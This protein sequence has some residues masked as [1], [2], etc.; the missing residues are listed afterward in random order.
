MFAS[1]GQSSGCTDFSR[2]PTIGRSVARFV[3]GRAAAAVSARIARLSRRWVVDNPENTACTAQCSDSDFHYH[4]EE[5]NL[6]WRADDDPRYVLSMSTDITE[7]KLAEPGPSETSTRNCVFQG[8]ALHQQQPGNSRAFRY[9]S[10]TM[11]WRAPL[12]AIDG[13]DT[14]AEEDYGGGWM[15]REGAPRVRPRQHQAMERLSRDCWSS[16]LGR[17]PVSTQEIKRRIARR[18][19]VGRSVGRAARRPPRAGDRSLPPVG[20]IARCCGSVGEPIATCDH[21]QRQGGRKPDEVSGR[22]TLTRM[23]NRYRQ[24][25]GI[26]EAIRGKLFGVFQ[27]AASRG[28]GQRHRV[29]ASPSSNEWFGAAWAA[30]YGT[31]GKSGGG[32][33]VRCFPFSLPVQLSDGIHPAAAEDGDQNCSPTIPKLVIVTSEA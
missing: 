27:R 24:R 12:R 28:R 9:G 1:T 21:V 7:R 26:F 4:E 33:C 2:D 23:S 14:D 22:Q 13:F 15:R 3:A 16:M 31:D 10:V 29:W 20:A 25:G 18:E 32:R 5:P 8:R 17:L 11:I 6:R 19:V 30:E